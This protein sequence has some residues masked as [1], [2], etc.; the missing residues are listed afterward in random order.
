MAAG[1]CRRSV[2]E[3]V[4]EG[5]REPHESAHARRWHRARSARPHRVGPSAQD[6]F[7][8]GHPVP[9][10]RHAARPGSVG[11]RALARGA[12]ALR[13]DAQRAP[14]LLPGL[15]QQRSQASLPIVAQ[16]HAG[17]GDAA[18]RSG[19]LSRLPVE[20][21]T[22]PAQARRAGAAHRAVGA[23][24]QVDQVAPADRGH[25]RFQGER[26]LRKSEQ[27][28]RI[29]PQDRGLP[30]R[31]AGEIS[32]GKPDLPERPR[33][34]RLVRPEARRTLVTS[35]RARR[36]RRGAGRR[37]VSRR[38]LDAVRT[39]RAAA[40]LEQSFPRRRGSQGGVRF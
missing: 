7:S 19:A 11:G 24:L 26:H 17:D 3:R 22:D 5:A 10:H 27:R 14:H 12:A 25:Q 32:G 4:G 31:R 35:R 23:W 9:E 13:P 39:R 40:G 18:R 20:W 34:R 36:E 6:C 33:A 8:Q 29:L 21:Q 37:D 2:H 30:R 1:D 15:S 28:P 16:L 38:A